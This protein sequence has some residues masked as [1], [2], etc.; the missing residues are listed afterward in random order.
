MP[1]FPP[2][3][4]IV[5]NGGD[6]P[7][8][9]RDGAEVVYENGAS[10]FIVAS[11][12]GESRLLLTGTSELMPSRADWSWSPFTIAFGGAN[13]KTSASTI[14]LIDCD[15]A[16]LRELPNRGGLTQSTY[17]SWDEDLRTIGAVDAGAPQFLALWRFSVD[18]SADPVQLTTTDDFC[19]GRPSAAPGGGNAPVVFAGTRGPFNQTF[20]QIWIVQPPPPEPPPRLKSPALHGRAPRRAHAADGGP[21]D[22]GA[23]DLRAARRM[24]AAAGPHRL[25]AR[26][27][28][29]VGRDRSAGRV[30]LR[31]YRPAARW[32]PA[33][34]T[35]IVSTLSCTS[36][37]LVKRS[38]T[39]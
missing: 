11:S 16:N 28:P 13:R 15:G 8:F 34:L 27:R 38:A 36:V 6:R 30:P 18:G 20:N 7:S 1:I 17:P 33:A 10:L 24:V 2:V 32:R 25:R 22:H 14:W 39:W 31:R 29:G 21:R 23:V 3:E 4:W 19:A 12:G 35:T 26:Q 9:S 37:P 5:P